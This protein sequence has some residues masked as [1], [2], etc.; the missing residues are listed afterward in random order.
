M[1]HAVECTCPECT[2]RALAAAN[3]RIAELEN[4]QLPKSQPKPK[5]E[6]EPAPAPKAR[7]RWRG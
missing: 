3:E 7:K 2:T 6:P 4:A 1:T 5:P